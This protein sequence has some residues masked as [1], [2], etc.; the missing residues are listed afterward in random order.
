LVISGAAGLLMGYSLIN[1][2]RRRRGDALRAAGK[3][4]LV[5]LITATL[6]MFMAAPIEGFFSFNPRVPVGAKIAFAI[7][8]AI[9]WGLFWVFYGRPSESG[10]EKMTG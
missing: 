4:A 6:M 3:D 7:V 5:L 10:D 9:A 8:S 2:G 1:P